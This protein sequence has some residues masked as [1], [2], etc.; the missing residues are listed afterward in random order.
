[1]YVQILTDAQLQQLV[2]GVVAEQAYQRGVRGHELAVGRGLEYACNNVLVQ[3]AIPALRSLQR[4]QRVRALGGVAQRLVQQRADDLLLD[5][6]IERAA[7]DRFRA[8]VLVRL[9][10]KYDDRLQT[11][12]RLQA[13]EGGQP[14]AVGQVEVQQ[15]DFVVPLLLEQRETLGKAACDLERERPV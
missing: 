3:F 12:L 4:Q 14:E 10:D 15:D 13:Q 6:E 11:D 7:L 8:D 5:Q 1:M 2:L 9:S